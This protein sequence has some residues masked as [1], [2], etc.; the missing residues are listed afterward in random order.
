MCSTSFFLQVYQALL[1]TQGHGN[2]VSKVIFYLSSYFNQQIVT[3]EDSEDLIGL[4]EEVQSKNKITESS[5]R[6]AE[7]IVMV[8]INS[9]ASGH[10]I[11]I[12][13]MKMLK[14]GLH[15]PDLIFNPFTLQVYMYNVHY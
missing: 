11:V 13:I 3:D 5:L 8:H 6:R 1:L 4:T 2:F 14:V 10:P 7:S 9:K 12:E 15:V